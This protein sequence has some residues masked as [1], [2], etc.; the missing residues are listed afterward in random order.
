MNKKVIKKMISASLS[1]GILGCPA[2]MSSVNASIVNLDKKDNSLDNETTNVL[3]NDDSKTTN[4]KVEY[5]SEI[6]IVS[7]NE[8]IKRVSETGEDATGYIYIYIFV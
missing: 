4:S 7:A 3:E 2:I 1:T 5:L 8:V 6:K